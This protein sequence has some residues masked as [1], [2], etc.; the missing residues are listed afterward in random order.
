MKATEKKE[1][2]TGETETGGVGGGASSGI[3]RVRIGMNVVA[4]LALL[5]AILILVNIVGYHYYKRWNLS[6]S[7][8]AR[9]SDKTEQVL[10][11]LAA[12]LRMS[13][14]LPERGFPMLS[15]VQAL[16][17]EYK[18]YGRPHVQ[19]E[20]LDTY[21]DFSRVAELQS[22]HRFSEAE[23]I[24]I[25]S[26]EGRSKIVDGMDLFTLD[27][28]M[29]M[30]GQEPEVTEFLAEQQLTGAIMEVVEG[31]QPLVYYIQGHLE[32]ALRSEPPLGLFYVYL[33][34]DNVAMQPLTLGTVERVPEDASMVSIIAPQFDYSE[35]DL[36]LLTRYWE[37]GGRLFVALNPGSKTP[38]LNGWLEERGILP[39]GDRVLQP[40]ALD[41]T[42]SIVF[43]QV[44]GLFV[45]GSPMT[46]RLVG[47]AGV[48]TRGTQS[49]GL[50][51]ELASQGWRLRSLIEA[52]PGFWG[53]VHHERIEEDGLYFDPEVDFGEPV[54]LAASVERLGVEDPR[55][56]LGG[57]RMVVVG[58]GSFLNEQ[59]LVEPNLLFAMAAVNWL[60]DREAFIGIPPREMKNFVLR[61]Q[62]DEWSKI[63]L[64]VVILIPG[65]AL[66][67]GVLVW[68]GRRR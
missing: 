62:P 43:D 13:V 60:T 31:R 55:V 11:S 54:T 8:R 21:K 19:V 25:I 56:A 41:A 20:L 17:E 6:F 34:R 4:Q 46:D 2:G 15:E 65:I 3:R 30:F 51:E 9:I 26:Y 27:T 14:I 5:L 37:G 67:L 36:E 33:E 1:P 49:L 24:I 39:R 32:P 35:R 63:F 64:L 29:A 59:D 28:S 57:A 40:V 45:G 16:L 58:N 53:E 47:A 22:E 48:F 18:Y 44:P 61:I 38:K 52:P 68:W 50:N 7:D 10:Q 12:P 42:T 66:S 23:S